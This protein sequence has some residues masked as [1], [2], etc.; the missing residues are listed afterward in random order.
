[1]ALLET[2]DA[3]AT[4]ALERGDMAAFESLFAYAQKLRDSLDRQEQ[5]HQAAAPATQA[6]SAGSGS[7][8]DQ[9]R[10]LRDGGRSV[11]VPAAR[12]AAYAEEWDG[13]KKS[14]TK[15]PLRKPPP[16]PIVVEGFES[17]M[18]PN[19]VKAD[20]FRDATS[21]GL[22]YLF[23]LVAFEGR[24][25]APS[26][27]KGT[28]VRLTTEEAC[29]AVQALHDHG[30][31]S[32]LLSLPILKKVFS[33][34]R[35]I[36]EALKHLC[37]FLLIE[38]TALGLGPP[39]KAFEMLV[40]KILAPHLK[41]CQV[42]KK[43]ARQA[44]KELE[45]ERM[46]N[47]MGLDLQKSTLAE[48]MRD[49]EAVCRI[50]A[51]E[52]WLPSFWQRIASVCVA[53]IC[54]IQ[55]SFGRSGELDG[56]Y[57]SEV[58]EARDTGKTFVVISRHRTVKTQG[59]LGRHLTPGAWTA[60]D[61]YFDLPPL[62]GS[63]WTDGTRRFLRPARPHMDTANLYSL[64]KTG[65][66]VYC[67]ENTFPRTNLIRK[68]MTTN[69]RD[70]EY[71]EKA[72]QMVAD[73][74]A[75]HLSTGESNYALKAVAKQA[76]Q[77]ESM[78]KNFFGA[79]VGWPSTEPTESVAEAK[80]R[81]LAKFGRQRAD[82]D[83]DSEEDT[84]S[85]SDGEDDEEHGAGEGRQRARS[86]PARPAAA[87]SKAKAATPRM[88]PRGR[89]AAA[90]ANAAADA[91][92]DGGAGAE[93]GQAAEAKAATAAANA[94]ASCKGAAASRRA[95][96]RR[97]ASTPPPPKATAVQ[98]DATSKAKRGIEAEAAGAQSSAA[99]QAEKANTKAGPKCADIASFVR[100]VP[101]EPPAEGPK[102]DKAAKKGNQDKYVRRPEARRPRV[103]VKTEAVGGALDNAQEGAQAAGEECPESPPRIILRD[104][105]LAPPAQPQPLA[106]AALDKELERLIGDQLRVEGKRKAAP[107]EPDR[108][109]RQRT[110]AA[111]EPPA[112]V[113][114][115]AEKENAVDKGAAIDE[116]MLSQLDRAALWSY[117]ARSRSG[118]LYPP[119]DI[120]EQCYLVLELRKA[121]GDR[122]ACPIK[123]DIRDMVTK[124]QKAKR[125]GMHVHEDQVRNFIRNFVKDAAANRDVD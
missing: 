82:D 123:L 66:K 60:T 33:W 56:L 117:N 26:G 61:K 97:P 67:P 65:G 54:V 98:V 27:S 51:G 115:G 19:R 86:A 63:S 109:T 113:E 96:M 84:D 20:S 95:A 119:L 24:L 106:D 59:K 13:E 76:A 70:E 57:E 29:G 5:R 16:S 32:K 87:V 21:M 88:R 69:V 112:A 99:A 58:R 53:W 101:F 116:E 4:D 23:H 10:E 73:F 55:G 91:R 72:K 62:E 71:K 37:S 105:G 40:N 18:V 75:H 46:A 38:C 118:C 7:L 52:E 104:G 89:L 41:E 14:R 17:F 114:G 93:Q 120:A 110:A 50:F 12:V 83:S 39:R 80:E 92:G 77:A 74:M 124:G 64:L 121:Q 31:L 2:L 36:L 44:R 122:D 28:T 100:R 90:E 35:K 11:A 78:I 6:P 111:E 47:Y 34:A 85:E 49:L 45:E 107:A 108:S 25:G 81:L 22:K 43:E 94:A 9:I 103:A 102:G 8:I 79:P 3:K 15:W 30:V 125:L 68:I 42:A 1:M 48:A